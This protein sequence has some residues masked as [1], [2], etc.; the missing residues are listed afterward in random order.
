MVS[1]C[2]HL[3]TAWLPLLQTSHQP[4]STV[5]RVIKTSWVYGST[6]ANLQD[7]EVIDMNQELG[8]SGPK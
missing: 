7:L 1:G 4:R 6:G 3:S 5:F 8:E 2:I